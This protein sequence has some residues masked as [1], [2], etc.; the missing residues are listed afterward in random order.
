M[1][2]GNRHILEFI[3]VASHNGFLFAIPSLVLVATKY[4]VFRNL[5]KT[6]KGRQIKV[7]H[8]DGHGSYISHEIQSILAN[9]GTIHKIRS[10]YSPQ[11]NALA[12]RRIRTIVEM[13][14]TIL[15]H[16]C[17]PPV[18]W[19]DAVLHSNYVRN[20]VATCVLKGKT[21]YRNFGD[22]NL[23]WNI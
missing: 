6:Q 10:P 19:E 21:S 11:Q 22:P 15:L 23:I 20:H 4:I 14:C 8:T 5:F 16:S 18:C 3:D 9:D 12:E 13:A 7:L 1:R 2:N 17:V